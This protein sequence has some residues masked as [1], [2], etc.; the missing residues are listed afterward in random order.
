MR[1]IGFLG[2]EH[3]RLM[4]STPENPFFRSQSKKK[5]ERNFNEVQMKKKY[6][7]HNIYVKDRVPQK[8]LLVFNVKDGWAPLCQF[9]GLSIP[10]VPFPRVNINSGKDG[11]M[12][13][14]WNS[15]AFMTKCK[16]EAIQSL[17]LYLILFFVVG[18][19]TLNTLL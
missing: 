10:D 15:S 19:V 11:Y 14:F 12:D 6:R 3:W 13:N 9:L 5:L 7:I 17:I 16:K 1:D 8:Q 4:F 18:Y 2:V